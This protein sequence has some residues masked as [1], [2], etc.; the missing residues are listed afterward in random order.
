[1]ISLVFLLIAGTAQATPAEYTVLQGAIA[2]LSL[3]RAAALDTLNHRI[4]LE[5][6]FLSQ[7]ERA[8][9]IQQLQTLKRELCSRP[10][11]GV[12]VWPLM[13]PM[14]FGLKSYFHY[15]ESCLRTAEPVV[16]QLIDATQTANKAANNFFYFII[17]CLGTMLLEA[18]YDEKI[19]RLFSKER[20]MERKI[21]H[22]IELL[23]QSS[24]T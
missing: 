1:M 11:A 20:R 22:M 13:V 9:L 4:A 12:L 17:A 7:E 15:Q 19:A 8:Q 21:N 18:E 2:T 23:K 5:A 10:G 3:D 16:A 24:S 6:P 14:W